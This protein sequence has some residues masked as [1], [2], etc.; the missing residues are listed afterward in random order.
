MGREINWDNEEDVMRE[1]DRSPYQFCASEISE[2][3][4]DNKKFMMPIVSLRP[5]EISEL[6]ERLRDDPEIMRIDAYS[7][8]EWASDRLK[9]DLSF[10]LLAI[11]CSPS[12]YKHASP[13]LKRHPEILKCFVERMWIF[14]CIQEGGSFS[15]EIIESIKKT[16]IDAVSNAEIYEDD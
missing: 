5:E 6:S 16:F 13:R 7:Q 14:E 2:R 4:L 10:M 1:W 15:K 8:L 12:G 3:L 9:D 11:D